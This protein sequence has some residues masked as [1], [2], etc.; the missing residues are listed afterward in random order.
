MHLLA[1]SDYDGLRFSREMI[2]S[3][4]GYTVHSIPSGA[5]TDVFNGA[6]F[7]LA[8]LCQS[9][10]HGRAAQVASVL[11]DGNPAIRILRVLPDRSVSEHGYDAVID[12]W[13]NPERF[14][15]AVRRLSQRDGLI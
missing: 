13:D 6:N 4:A 10:E 9:V 2:L 5:V 11:R 1:I 14:L 15:D 3:K 12:G 7:Q 8:I